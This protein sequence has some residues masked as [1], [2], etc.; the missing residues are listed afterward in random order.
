VPVKV[1]H[2]GV[3]IRGTHWLDFVRDH[4]DTVSVG[5]VD[6][7]SEALNKARDKLKDSECKYFSDMDEALNECHADAVLI[8][9]PSR[10]H[11]DHATAAL[12]KGLDVMVEKPF[13]T[14][15]AEALTVLREAEGAGR[16]IVVAENYRYWPAERTM[17]Q[18]I[19]AGELGRIDNVLLVDHRNMP[20]Y[21]EGPWLAKIDYPQ[22]GE[23]G[24]HH[25]DSLRAL[26][27]VRPTSMTTK[28]W[29]PPKSDY[30]HGAC[31]QALMDFEGIN[32]NYLGTLTSDRFS[33]TLRVEGEAGSLWSNRKYVLFRAAG[34]RIYR[35]VKRVK[36]PAGDEASYPKGGTSSLLNSLR[37]AVVHGT[38]AETSGSDNLWTLA[39]VEAGKRS[40]QE[41]R[42]VSIEEIYKP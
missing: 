29:N 13:A 26:L 6:P 42:T 40:D 30:Q 25:F 20:S 38:Q 23:I 18:M 35:P 8:A 1:L 14:S 11:K 16:Q 10:F 31:T 39:M 2:V 32:V 41:R 7:D 19:L 27:G 36:V 34:K 17:R 9:S 24:I 12:R 5:C 37:D 15:V 33:F 22:L 3:G 28:V 4:P 21:T